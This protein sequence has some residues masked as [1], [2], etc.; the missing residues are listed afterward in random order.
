MKETVRTEEEKMK[1]L[2]ICA[3]MAIKLTIESSS[4][5]S[6]IRSGIP[7]SH[8]HICNVIQEFRWTMYL[9]DH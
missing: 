2:S 8:K 7:T 1:M 4:T 9:C 6:S 5:V 3:Y